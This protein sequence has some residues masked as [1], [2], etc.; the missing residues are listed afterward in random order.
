M[1]DII[2]PDLAY[3][4]GLII[5]RGTIRVTNGHRQLII[6]FPFR[7]LVAKGLKS[8]YETKD[9]ISAS[10]DEIINRMGELTGIT[11]HKRTT[12]TSVSI[13][14]DAI[15]NSYIW[16]IIDKLLKGKRSFREMEI[17]EPIFES[18]EDIKKELLRGIADVTGSIGL[19]GR[20]QVGRHRVYVSILYDN[21]KLPIQICKL[22]QDSPLRIPV[23]TIDWGHPNIRNGHMT[24]YNRGSKEFWAKEHQLKIYAEYFEKIGFR[25][26]HKNKILKELA[27]YNKEKWPNR[28]SNICAPPKKRLKSRTVHPE[29]NSEKLPIFLKGKHCDSYWQVCLLVGCKQGLN[30]N[31]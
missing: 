26:D 10:L 30:E 28:K 5:G 6:E 12:K 9:K 16:R 25:I 18:D 7:N 31:V 17:P 23:M 29:E 13:T 22:L 11:P 27:E 21:W 14:F 20:D 1:R 4:L 15:K 8:K 3:L 19:G 24:R 2:D